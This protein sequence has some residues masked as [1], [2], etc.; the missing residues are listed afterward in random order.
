MKTTYSH[1][2]WDWHGV[3]GLSGFWSK[4]SKIVDEVAKF[5]SYVFSEEH[6]IKSWMLGDKSISELVEESEISLSSE[7]LTDLLISDWKDSGAVNIALF[8]S[9]KALYPQASHSIITDNM[10]VFTYYVATD[11]FLKENFV[12]IF[13][14][15]Q[16]K[17]LKQ[18]KPG[19]FESAMKELG[20]QSFAGCLMLDDNKQG[21][22]LVN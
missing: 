6:L 20:F 1:I 18:N 9:I 11:S 2:F 12:S 5:T 7:Y 21:S 10:D 4:S 15:C 22:R 8:S 13:N 16:Y 3:L 17:K 19:L 14:S